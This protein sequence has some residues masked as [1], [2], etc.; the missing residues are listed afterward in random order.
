MEPGETFGKYLLV[1]RIATGGMADIYLA[2]QSGVEGFQKACVI[3]RILPQLAEDAQFVT[4]FL[5]EARIAAMLSHPNV[6]QIFDLGKEGGSYYL[7]MEHIHGEDLARILEAERARGRQAVPVPLAVKILSQVAEG[8][9]YA[10]NAVD[11]D[12]QPLHIVHRDVSPP[13]VI[14]AYSGSVKLVDFGVAKAVVKHSHTEVGVIKGKVPYMSPEQVQGYQLDGRSDIFSMGVLLYELTTGEKPFPGDNVAQLCMQIVNE[15][16]RSPVQ[17]V[18]QYPAGL[19]KI[20]QRALAKTPEDRYPSA[21]DMQLELERFLTDSGQQ[22][23]TMHLGAYMRE[24]F[25]ESARR[26]ASSGV[27]PMPTPGDTP[28]PAEA[29]RA[30]TPHVKSAP[31]LAFDETAAVG[32]GK[33]RLRRRRG[34]TDEDPTIIDPRF[35]GDTLPV[36]ADNAAL[37]QSMRNLRRGPGRAL[38][39]LLL[40]AAAGGG[41]YYYWRN[42]MAVRGETLPQSAATGPDA[43]ANVP[44]PSTALP[45]AGGPAVR[46]GGAAA[47]DGGLKRRRPDPTRPR[48][49]AGKPK[50][51]AHPHA[52]PPTPTRP[53]APVEPKPQAHLPKDEPA[54]PAPAPAP[55]PAPPAPAPNAPA[56]AQ[57][58]PAPQ[59]PSK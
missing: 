34:D 32:T 36:D 1:R 30:E 10:H 52:P 21:G 45:D 2:R 3:K 6:V 49:L 9:H 43:A 39:W 22:C 20:L 7:A 17:Y 44:Q 46:D 25:P 29:T 48:P 5:D 50:P 35:R 38:M 15:P 55:T 56:P 26:T 11:E 31:R 40:L 42:R 24:L 58:S 13:N 19:W 53:A 4:M 59:E 23:T 16:P 18:P 54:P 27:R 14:V 47:G 8:L 51:A 33:K 41:G 12:D 57:P 28:R 37:Q